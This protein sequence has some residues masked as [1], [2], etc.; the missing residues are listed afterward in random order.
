MILKLTRKYVTSKM[1]IN[2][3]IL[4]FLFYSYL[5]LVP[6]L[7][8]DISSDNKYIVSGSEDRSIKLFDLQAKKEI[9]CF[10]R[11]HQRK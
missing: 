5:F 1:S 4:F 11:I 2:V 10:E 3:I 6:I 8:V 7:S 9:H